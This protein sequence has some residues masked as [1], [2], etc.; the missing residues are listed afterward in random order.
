LGI[1]EA[2]CNPE[3]YPKE[4]VGHQNVQIAWG[5]LGTRERME[6]FDKLL[7]QAKDLAKTDLE[8]RRVA[9]FELGV[10][11]YMAEGRKQYAARQESPIPAVRA[12]RVEDAQGDVSKVNWEKAALLGGTWYE[13][14]QDK[15]AARRLSGRFA[16]DGK[17]FYLEL[18]DPCETKKLMTSATVFPCDDWEIFIAGQRALPYRQY[19]VGPSGMVAALSHGEVNWRMNVKMEDHGIKAASDTSAPDKWVTRLAMPLANVV[20]NGVA[21]G[22]KLYMNV[23]RVTSPELKGS[24]GFGIDTWVPFCTVHEVDRLAEI[25]LD[26]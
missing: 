19:A 22:G 8:K 17:F 15:P 1:E 21:P 4:R 12:P 26:Q 5:R 24:P 13:R 9:L 6:Q 7:Q 25:T 3:N 20:A 18:T 2:Y 11:N 16:H 14:G 23:I 10:W